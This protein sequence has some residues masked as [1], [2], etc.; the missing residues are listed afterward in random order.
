MDVHQVRTHFDAITALAEAV[1]ALGRARDCIA[2]AYGDVIPAASVD[3]LCQATQSLLAES[4]RL[5]TALRDHDDPHVAEFVRL[6][7][8]RL[9][10]GPPAAEPAREER[11]G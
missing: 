5:F 7:L 3:V 11:G 6:A 2:L 1:L 8:A 10:H 9:Q 4:G